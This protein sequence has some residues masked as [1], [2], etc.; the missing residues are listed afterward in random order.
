M[1]RDLVLPADRRAIGQVRHQ[2]PPLVALGMPLGVGRPEDGA[3]SAVDQVTLREPAAHRLAADGRVVLLL[4][5][6]GRVVLLVE[7]QDDRHAGPAA[8]EE[9]E[10]AGCLGGHP[11]DD[12]RDPTE[13]AAK[14]AAPLPPGQALDPLGLEP[15]QPAVDGAAA[16]EEGRQEVGP[17]ASLGQEEQDEGAKAEFGVGILPVDREQVVALLGRQ[18]ECGRHGASGVGSR[19]GPLPEIRGAAHFPFGRELLCP[20]PQPR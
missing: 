6:D 13:P 5:A 4:A 3:G 10:V 1:H 19:G 9:A 20:L 17:G 2:A 14:G 18:G 8:A 11:V 16:P 7:P 12:D 15:L